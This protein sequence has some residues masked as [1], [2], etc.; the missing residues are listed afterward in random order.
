M[1]PNDCQAKKEKSYQIPPESVRRDNSDLFRYSVRLDK[2]LRKERFP[3]EKPEQIIN[4]FDALGTVELV[5][6]YQD[7]DFRM[8]MEK[9]LATQPDLDRS[10]M[11][12][13][14]LKMTQTEIAG[15]LGVCQATVCNRF[16]VIKEK[17]AEFYGS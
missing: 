15:K 17:F 5:D 2:E 16:K 14:L 12:M 11:R 10:I 4:F 1:S 8:D 9:F 13:Y 7:I 3:K 6:P